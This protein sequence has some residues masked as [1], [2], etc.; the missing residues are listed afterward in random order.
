MLTPA[1]TI[2]DTTNP[3]T[4]FPKIPMLYFFDPDHL[5]YDWVQLHQIT[6][7]DS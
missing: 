2:P 3:Q 7:M 1:P 4:A 5:I 6:H